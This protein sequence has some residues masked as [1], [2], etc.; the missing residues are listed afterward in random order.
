MIHGL[1][2]CFLV[3]AEVNEHSQHTSAH[4]TIARLLSQED[5]IAIA[6]QVLAEFVH[7]V[8]DPRRFVEPLTLTIAY[9]IALKWWTAR[10]TVQVFP[11]ERAVLRYL[12]WAQQ[13]SLG[14][15]RQLDTLLA[16]TYESAG[17][18]SLLTYND[19][20]FSAYGCFQIVCPDA[21]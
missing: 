8:T 15:K 14:R 12:A 9:D 10:D 18:I 2:T 16:A 3:A 5:Q 17:I 20:D 4:A 19:R 1:D 13:L 11:N 6:P 21:E 7:I